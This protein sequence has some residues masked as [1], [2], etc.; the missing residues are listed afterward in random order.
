MKLLLVLFCTALLRAQDGKVVTTEVPK[1]DWLRTKTAAAKG[2]G[3]EVRRLDKV[4][5]LVLSGTSLEGPSFVTSMTFF[6]ITDEPATLQI[7]LF[8]GQGEPI[9]LPIAT[10]PNTFDMH[11]ELL[12]DVPARATV[13]FSTFR[14][15]VRLRAV[16]AT[17]ASEPAGAIQVMRT[18]TVA[19]G[20]V[21]ANTNDFAQTN[22]NLGDI[23]FV[24]PSPAPLDLYLLNASP[25]FMNVKVTARALNGTERCRTSH[26][27]LSGQLLS[28]RLA[29]LSRCVASL[30]DPYVLDVVADQPGL[31]AA[32]LELTRT[33]AYSHTMIP[34]PSN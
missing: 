27:V 12:G 15:N 34:I 25:E 16:Y 33:S 22:E 24:Q 5:P 18:Q 7:R 28:L 26:A 29:D 20:S 14:Q 3:L 1:L 31:H 11:A 4:F 13:G 19:L 9:A 2:R 10:G 21:T 17:V 23:L 32:T 8:D 30:T 6:N